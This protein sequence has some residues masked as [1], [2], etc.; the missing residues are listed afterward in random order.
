MG[1]R[2]LAS[3]IAALT[4]LTSAGCASVVPG[5]A[6]AGKPSISAK[7]GVATSDDGNGV[8]LGTTQDGAA[9]AIDLFVEPQ[10][11]HCGHFVA[12]Y[13]DAI[14]KDVASN[15][16]V[17]TIRPLTFM[18]YGSDD[19]S[20]RATNA[21][22]LV[23]ADDTATPALVWKF[24]QGLYAKMMSSGSL[25]NDD[26]IAQVAN[27]VGVPPDTVNRIAA[28]IPEVNGDAVGEGN[29]SVMD[30]YGVEHATPT[31][32]DTVAKLQV[33]FDDPQWLDHLAK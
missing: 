3:V 7:A 9:A 10:C 18:D 14:A 6:V 28:A 17:V 24:I 30:D 27:D 11:P 20:A 25:A 33:D 23:A 4:L 2:T 31:V 21:I 16:L 19:Y 22:F 12:E 13:G 29:L 1:M 15:R 5:R 26:G 32:Y 8:V